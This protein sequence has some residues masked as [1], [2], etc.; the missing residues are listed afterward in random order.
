MVREVAEARLV[1]P[2]NT[3]PRVSVIIVLYGRADM[4]IPA[5]AALIAN[6]PPCFELIIVDNASPDDALELVSSRVVGAMIVRNSL[7]VGFSAGVD[8]GA[9]HARGEFLL[10]LNSDV[11]VEPGWLPPLLAALDRSPSLAGVSPVLLNIDGSVQ[12]AGSLL[13]AGG[14]TR[15]VTSADR[16]AL[17]FS[18]TVPY[19]SAACLLLRRSVF[20]KLGGLDCVYGLGYYED[21]ELAMELDHLG[22]SLGYVA[23]SSA[24]HVHGASSSRERAMR[25]TVHNRAIFARRWQSRLDELP[26]ATDHLTASAEVRARDA[27]AVDRVLIIDDRVPQTDR[28]SGDPRMATIATRLAALWPA[29][30][31]TL[32]GASLDGADRY[33]PAL[34]AAGVEVAACSFDGAQR[35]LEQRA[36]HYSAIIISR[37]DNLLRFR[38]M[39]ERT[40]P[41]ALI[42]A[43]VE[44]IYSRRTAMRATVMAASD[45]ALAASCAEE[46]VRQREV[47]LEGWNWAQVAVCVSREEAAEVR[48]V[49]PG[50]TVHVLPPVARAPERLVPY[51]ERSGVVFFGGFMGGEAS[52][53]ADSV[54]HLVDDIMP[55]L[56]SRRP[57]LALT[58]AG[59]DPTP[60]ILSR[61]GERVAV[62]G[63]VD[64]PFHTLGARLVHVVPER[65]GAGVKT[66]LIESMASGTPFV[67]SPIGAQGL[68]LGELARHLVADH[69]AQ[70]A[71]MTL[72]LLDDPDLWR[73]VQRG[74]AGLAEQH[75]SPLV[76]DR[77]LVELM[78][79]L[80]AAPPL[81][82]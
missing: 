45:P 67:T 13:F 80:G 23:G 69:P 31:V 17:D 63:R 66:K 54:R 4:A 38:E 72:A 35:W 28:G 55:L 26:P 18:R 9:L 81:G 82:P 27:F 39:V 25:R 36:G 21:V 65:F 29:A 22:L 24:R 10:L 51:A 42:V 33:A 73:F 20:T 50:T 1:V 77:T 43:D 41:L 79:D 62:I 75:F 57:Q 52:P 78:A 34:L 53:N 11:F 6:S 15:A 64:D 19:V 12:E 58:V 49:A 56:W 47:E 16:W 76:L 5:I 37:T 48:A 59:S 14:V 3:R 71:E 44:A 2:A 74:L 60:S 46:A 32:L 7:N 8:V 68:H 61:A 30:R 40:Q 70:F